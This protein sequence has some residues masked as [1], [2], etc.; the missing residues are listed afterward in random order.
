[1]KNPNVVFKELIKSYLLDH[2]EGKKELIEWFLNNVMDEEALQQIEAES[3][4]RSEDRKGYRNGSR[5]RMLKTTDGE[6]VLNKPQIR[7]FPFKTRVFEK[8]SRVEKALESLIIESYINGVSPRDIE[9]VVKSLGVG[10]VSPEYVSRL[11]KGLDENIK[12]FMDRPLENEYKFLYVDATYFKVRHEGVY[13]NRALFIA[14]GINKEGRREIISIEVHE[15]E[16]YQDWYEFFDNIR[17]R[18]VKDIE[19]LISDG[20][21]GIRESYNDLYNGSWQYCHIHFVRNL[22][23]LVPKKHWK[24]L[25]LYIKEALE[26]E[27]LIYVVQDK[28]IDLGIE[29]GS[30]MFDEYYPYL[31]NYKAFGNINN[32]RLK[33]TNALERLNGELKRRTKKARAYPDDSSLLR[34]VVSIMMDINEEWITGSKYINMEVD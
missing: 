4:E 25:S 18:G 20:N 28:L 27:S 23:K 12:S 32:K 8:Y 34:V 29:K 9:D 30:R 13:R 26:N 5:K 10:K 11:N 17:N 16:S 31:Y 24:E 2:K 3:Y 22:L 14:I 15:S 33:N 6:L 19:M 7:E 21:K 1:M